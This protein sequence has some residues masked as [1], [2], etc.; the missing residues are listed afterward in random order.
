MGGLP[1]DSLLATIRWGGL[2]VAALSSG[3]AFICV[4]PYVSLIPPLVYPTLQVG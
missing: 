3:V 4:F 1:E 2:Q